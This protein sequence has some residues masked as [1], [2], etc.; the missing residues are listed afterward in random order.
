VVAGFSNAGVRNAVGQ[1]KRAWLGAR[2]SVPCSVLNCAL[3]CALLAG[4][5]SPGA[6]QSAGLAVLAVEPAAEQGAGALR[7]RLDRALLPH[8]GTLTLW[9]DRQ[10]VTALLQRTGAAEWLLPAAA[11]RWIGPATQLELWL[12]SEG[13]WQALD[14]RALQAAAATPAEPARPGAWKPRIDL[15]LKS[16]SRARATGTEPTPPRA[17]YR[18]A[19]LRAA[20]EADQSLGAYTLRGSAQIAGS[21]HRAEALRYAQRPSD[22]AKL[23]LAEYRFDLA[24]NDMTLAA[25]HLGIGNHPLLLDRHASRGLSAGA[26]GAAGWDL[27]FSAVNGSAIVGFANPLGLAESEHQ[28]HLIV[29]G[30]ELD[31][32]RPGW[33][34]AE[35][36]WVDASIQASGNFN[37]GEVP[38]AE[39]IR[40]LGLRLSGKLLD[41]RARVDISAGRA[42][43]RAAED[44]QLAATAAL[45]P[46]ADNTRSA[47]S[48]DLAFDLV[49]GW[50]GLVERLPLTLTLQLR[51]ARVEPLYKAV[52][53]FL[54]ADQVFDRVALL[55]TV[56]AAQLQLFADRKHDNVDR[57]ATLLTTRTGNHGLALYLPAA[58]WT[59]TPPPAWVPGLNLQITGNTQRA[60]D[61]PDFAT[62]GVAATH[63]PDQANRSAQAGL[64][65]NLDGIAF[66]LNGQRSRQ[67]NR[68][69]GRE[70]ADFEVDG[71][72]AQFSLPLGE[73]LSMALGGGRQRNRSIERNLSE[74]TD[75]ATLALDWRPGETW[76]LAL[77]LSAQRGRDS[78]GQT[79]SRALGWQ[80][81]ITRRFK[82]DALG[83][84]ASPLPGQWFLRQSWASSRRTDRVFD[85]ASNGRLWTLQAGLG[86]SFGG[87]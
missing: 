74:E 62:S 30:Q 1:P 12:V 33:L 18:D 73:Q 65:W 32:A 75:N 5:P 2:C 40:G 71:L 25:G 38:D 86:L 20:L 44:P 79:A 57:I 60:L 24:G 26:R 10:D 3:M 81:Q 85:V 4:A 83:A 64:A 66:N 80:A 45:T 53:A 84:L 9:I 14:R 29:V 13:R 47:W 31:P 27:S 48:G 17:T 23:D 70:Q 34:R 19:T 54:G 42:R 28:V 76:A 69:T 15:A 77:A 50:A 67:D 63:R 7:I 21:S 49:Q 22:A 61:A 37:R 72:S 51:H 8:E 59:A 52:G 56:G 82:F 43:H 78:A 41:G 87:Q 58:L 36:S 6:A 35:L 68:Q 39:K 11:S 16:Q 55:T 46:L